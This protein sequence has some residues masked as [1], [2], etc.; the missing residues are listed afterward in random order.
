MAALL[1]SLKIILLHLSS[2]NIGAKSYVLSTP[3]TLKNGQTLI[4]DNNR[5]E[6]GFFN[7]S[8]GR[9]RGTNRALWYLG[10]WYQQITP[11]T[12][13][14]V[15]NRENPLR[16]NDVMLTMNAKG[17]LSLRD[18]QGTLLP[19]FQSVRPVQNP[20]LTLLNSGNLVLEDSRLTRYAWQ[21]FDF[22]SDTLLP[23]MKLGRA[24][25]LTSWKH[26]N[27]PSPGE[28]VLGMGPPGL[29]QLLLE[30]NGLTMSRW[31][32]WNGKSFSGSFV[33]DNPV[34]R[35][36]YSPDGPSFSYEVADGRIPVR[37]VVGP[38]GSVQFSK[39]KVSSGSWVPLVP[40]NKDACDVYSSCGPYGICNPDEPGFC[41]CLDG[42]V[43]SSPNE[44]RSLDFSDGCRRKNGLNCSGGGSGSDGFVKYVGLKLPDKF[45]VRE[46]LG[47]GLEEC[48][49]SCRE[50]CACMAYA[51]VDL[52]GNGTQCVV[53]L[54]RL[55]DLRDAKRDG[56]EIYIRMARVELDDIN[57]RK[58]KNKVTLISSL[59]VAAYFAA[60]I[61]CA[62]ISCASPSKKK[63]KLG[64]VQDKSSVP[65]QDKCEEQYIQLFNMSVISAATND[66]SLANK[67]GQG[68]Y[69]LV[70]QGSLPDEQ[71][72]AIKR[73]SESSKQGLR[74]FKNEM[75]LIAQLQHRNLVKLLGCCVEGDERMLVYEYMA[76]KSLDQFIFSSAKKALLLWEKR[77]TILKGVAKGLEYLHF[78]SRLRVIHRD[79]KASNILLDDEL[80]PKIADFGLARNSENEKEET[81][82][83]V[84][85]THGYMS[86]E[87][88]IN[89]HYSIKSDV[90]SFGVLALEIISGKRNWGFC[91][92][93]HDFN[94]LGHAWKLWSEGKNMELIDPVIE[95]SLLESQVIRCIQI[96][97]LCVQHWPE[98]RPTMSQVVCM[99]ENENVILSEP[100]EPGFFGCRSSSTAE[101]ARSNQVTVNGLT[102]TDLTGRT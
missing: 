57:N 100:Q 54:D 28:F 31:G 85:G 90:F 2:T 43:E 71:N 21:S 65:D 99:L 24:R 8:S 33:R 36:V 75:N 17:D 42:F 64:K 88:V 72:I 59:L 55:V 16:G 96:G 46:G 32:P 34:F 81:T 26:A 86:P 41:R 101:F 95:D 44:W 3:Y 63:K 92:P 30:E 94:L 19:L 1:C 35:V 56:D 47:L 27:D 91:H 74:E 53:W 22:P 69:G 93:D 15:A 39:W 18:K 51:G 49:E 62:L 4:S 82:R 83:R 25:V 37:L 6:L 7:L 52:Y 87:Y 38:S 73:L 60:V 11:L 50:D 61:C 76:N 5:F 13:I 29:P 98:G 23:G 102:V 12:V 58:K 48:G 68:G 66:F 67:I 40:V 78:G 97:L 80:N 9:A 77:F 14:W 45:R 79:L 10:I 84:I 20:K 89:G 70:Y